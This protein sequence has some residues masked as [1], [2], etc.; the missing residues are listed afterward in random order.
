VVNFDA[1]PAGVNAA[2]RSIQVL[3][4]E[5]MR[6]RV[7]E[8]SGGMDPDEF[9]R[10]RGADAYR[11]AYEKAPR[12]FF[13]LADRA[14]ARF[15]VQSAEGRVEGL[16]FLLPS[17]QRIPDKIERVAIAN[18]VAAYLG[19]DASLVLEQF[20]KAAAARSETGVQAAASDLP[21]TEKLLARCLIESAEARQQLGSRVRG[22]RSAGLRL[23][24][25]F[26]AILVSGEP[27]DWSAAEA[28]LDPREATLLNEIHFADARGEGDQWEDLL[29][30]AVACVETI[31]AAARAGGVADLKA[32]VR[33]A[34]R[35]GRLEEALS[36]MRELEHA[37]RE[38]LRSPSRGAVI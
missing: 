28:R 3:L 11:A 8:L 30:Q 13:W 6:I 38:I 10:A 17:I 34:E 2:E 32:R 31:E 37:E 15:D 24:N 23:H 22:L 4:E 7:L 20:R 1:D 29:A 33:E 21:A 5:D 12:Y 18:D 9:V 16:R 27:P 26:E 19:V 25:V 35:E 14:R 36:L